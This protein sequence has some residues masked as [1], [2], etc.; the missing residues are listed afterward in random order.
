MWYMCLRDVSAGAGDIVSGVCFSSLADGSEYASGSPVRYTRVTDGRSAGYS[1]VWT[2][3][4][5][6]WD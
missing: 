3:G 6:R 4:T 1:S 5:S 2:G